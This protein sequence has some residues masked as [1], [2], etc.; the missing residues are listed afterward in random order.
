MRDDFLYRNV[1]A[2]GRKALRLGLT[3]N[4]GVKGENLKWGLTGPK[5]RQ[6]LQENFHREEKRK[7]RLHRYS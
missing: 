2:F 3:A 5:N 7:C 6:Q 1:A 4:C